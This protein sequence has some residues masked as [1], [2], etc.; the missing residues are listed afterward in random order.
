MKFFLSQ[1]I[2]YFGQKVIKIIDNTFKN[3]IKSLI[4]KKIM[5]KAQQQKHNINIRERGQF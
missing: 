3:N 2:E 4:N 5:L 1:T